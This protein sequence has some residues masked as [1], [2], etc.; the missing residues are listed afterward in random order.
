MQYLSNRGALLWIKTFI[1][2]YCR[3]FSDTCFTTFFLFFNYLCAQWLKKNN[4]LCIIKNLSFETL[5]VIVQKLTP[6]QTY[7]E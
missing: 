3:V 7:G 5:E 4:Y 1:P 6:E 2:Y